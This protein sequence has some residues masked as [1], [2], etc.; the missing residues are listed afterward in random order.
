[1]YVAY[2]L[3]RNHIIIQFC[4]FF[5]PVP[6]F[7]APLI[8]RYM[9]LNN[10]WFYEFWWQLSF[11]FFFFNNIRVGDGCVVLTYSSTNWMGIWRIWNW[12]RIIIII[13]RMFFFF[14]FLLA[15]LGWFKISSNSCWYSCYYYFFDWF[16]CTQC[17]SSDWNR[18]HCIEYWNCLEFMVQPMDS[19]YHSKIDFCVRLFVW[20]APVL[21][22]SVT[23]SVRSN[24][25]TFFFFFHFANRK[26]MHITFM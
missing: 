2:Q 11:F 15:F 21:I 24:V 19:I 8:I 13:Y 17:Q 9:K 4:L 3:S 23:R 10:L 5:D 26:S 6:F 25:T 18:Y 20:P 7:P 14:F 22:D 12:K 1:M 16:I